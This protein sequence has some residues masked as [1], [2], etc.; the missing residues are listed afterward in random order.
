MNQIGLAN[1]NV[2]FM[3]ICDCGCQEF[4]IAGYGIRCWDCSEYVDFIEVWNED[5][6]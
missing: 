2:E 3:H 6:H 4:E 5:I 1:D